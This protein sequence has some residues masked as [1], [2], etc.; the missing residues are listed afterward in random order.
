[1]IN[2]FKNQGTEDIFDGKNSKAA[3]KICPRDLW[4]I[5]ARKL[6]Q[7]DSAITLNDL[8][9]PL[10]NRLEALGK[11]RKGQHSIRINDQ[12]RVCFNW[13]DGNAEYVEI[14]DYHQ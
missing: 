13:R 12:F 6:E 10:G 1:M 3:R 8:R 14:T 5:A 2:S 9:V 4:E 11:D 7:I